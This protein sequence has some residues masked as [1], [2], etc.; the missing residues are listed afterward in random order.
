MIETNEQPPGKLFYAVIKTA[1]PCDFGPIGLDQRHVY[2]ITHQDVGA[3]VSDYPRVNTIKLLR[4]NIAPYHAAISEAVKRFTTIPAKFPQIARDAGEVAVAL[5]R[6]YSRIRHGL[7]RLD[8]KV[9]MG[10]KV[11]WTAENVLEFF[12]EKDPEIKSRWNRMKGKGPLNRFDQIAFGEFFHARMA[13]ARIQMADL[14]RQ[15]IPPSEI[16]I[17]EVSEESMASNLLILIRKDLQPALET[18]IRELNGGL[19]AEA[20]ITVDGPWPPFSFVDH[21]EIIM[22]R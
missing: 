12:V 2:S 16:K 3:L 19:G 22:N 4:K 14:I 10:L 9:E 1:Q 7:D 18:A 11:W 15:A 5:Q 20:R 6:N 17:E 8:E 13:R 21:L